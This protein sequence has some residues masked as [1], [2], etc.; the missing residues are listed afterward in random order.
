[1]NEIEIEIREFDEDFKEYFLLAFESP[2]RQVWKRMGKWNFLVWKRVR[3]GDSGGTPPTKNSQE[4]P[5]DLEFEN[6]NCLIIA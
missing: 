5:L 6:G 3:I 1:M 4:Y 2:W